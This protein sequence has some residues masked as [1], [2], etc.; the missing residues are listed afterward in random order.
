MVNIVRRDEQVQLLKEEY[1]A[2]YVLNSNSEDFYTEFT[3]LVKKL[4]ATALIECVGGDLTGNLLECL[5]S[6]STCI[7]YGALSEKPVGCIDPLLLI[8]RSYTIESFILG[9][10]LSSKGMWIVNTI[11]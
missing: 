3:T 11:R 2:E 5:P 4:K 8:G 6:R 7:L 10:W 9:N 1:G